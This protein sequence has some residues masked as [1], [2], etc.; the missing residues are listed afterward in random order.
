LLDLADTLEVEVGERSGLPQAERSDSP[1]RRARFP[2]P[3]NLSA[4]RG[5]HGRGQTPLLH[6]ISPLP[7]PLPLD[8]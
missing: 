2:A 6:W 7:L 4:R 1:S 8:L 5:D 3:P